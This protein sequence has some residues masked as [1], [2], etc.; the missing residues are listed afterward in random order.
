MIILPHQAVFLFTHFFILASAQYPRLAIAPS[1]IPPVKLVPAPFKRFVQS[2]SKSY[3][4]C[5]THPCA[6]KSRS[7]GCRWNERDSLPFH[8]RNKRIQLRH[9][10]TLCIECRFWKEFS[11]FT[12]FGSLFLVEIVRFKFTFTPCRWSTR[13]RLS[14]S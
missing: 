10:S 6:H 14:G 8:E 13:K 11:V 5:P 1:S 12:K 7:L 3:C 4:V 9:I 2:T